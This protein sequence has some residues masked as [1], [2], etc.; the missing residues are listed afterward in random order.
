MFKQ[1]NYKKA[2]W[3]AISI[4]L[5]VLIVYLAVETF[6]IK[7]DLNSVQR[8]TLTDRYGKVLNPDTQLK[9]N[10]DVPQFISKYIEKTGKLA[11]LPSILYPTNYTKQTISR[12]LLK[13]VSHDE[14]MKTLM[15]NAY[16]DFGIIGMEGGAHYYFQKDLQDTSKLEQAFLLSKLESKRTTDIQN[17]S[18]AFLKVLS[19]NG[20][21]TNSEYSSD[22]VKMAELVNSLK[23][24]HTYAQSYVQEALLESEKALGLSEVDLMRKGYR[25]YT[26]LDPQLQK[27][28]YSHFQQDD[29]FPLKENFKV[30]SGMV[31]ANKTTG[32][33]LGLMGGRDYQNSSLNRASQ[34]KRQPAS[35][36]KPL[37]VFAP[38]IDLGWKP[39]ALLKDVPMVVGGYKPENYDYKYRGQVSFKDTVIH[40]YNVP[41]V[42][43][44]SQIGLD[45]GMKYV[46]NFGL[47]NVN[48][49]DG[50]KN[51]L[52]FLSNGTS[53]LTMA[54]AYTI[55]PNDGEMVQV[56]TIREIKDTQGKRIYLPNQ[57]KKRIIK[58]ETANEMNKLLRSVV[59]DG[60][61]N[62]ANIDGQFVAG[63]TGTTSY[64]GWFV[65]YTKK[66]VTAV[67]M[68]SDVITPNNQLTIDGGG[69]PSILFKKVM[70]DLSQQ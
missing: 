9:S 54:E 25:I 26:N 70:T 33:V 50:Y 49:N 10:K 64:D 44:L 39:N 36:F 61:A 34:I 31:I 41:T 55:F 59:L 28:L 65:G 7:K 1:I 17:D 2:S 14:Q 47:F 69:Y 46:N 43:L 6:T 68:G 22:K 11:E 57:E 23:N 67:W 3:I 24:A 5:A 21:I 15:N 40:S 4:F 45:K 8:T 51:A 13:T 37:I 20:V 66:Y 42:W 38:A 29:N 32:E 58:K 56:H 19:K 30:E 52:G 63:K 12:F 48:Q 27:T 53:P 16:M 35:T 18:Q 62:K 60:T